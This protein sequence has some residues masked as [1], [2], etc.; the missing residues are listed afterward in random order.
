MAIL[1]GD[2][3]PRG[4]LGE[5]RLRQTRQ[6]HRGNRQCAQGGTTRDIGR[7]LFGGG[8]PEWTAADQRN[9]ATGMR[10]GSHNAQAQPAQ[11]M[12]KCSGHVSGTSR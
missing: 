10:F 12:Q 1:Q 7:I 8:P 9:P 3:I 5:R 4:G 6:R 2:R 11:G